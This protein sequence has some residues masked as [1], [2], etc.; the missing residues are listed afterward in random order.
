MPILK[1]AKKA[2][3]VSQRKT[4]INRRIKSQVKTAVDKVKAEPT[5]EN[6]NEAYTAIDMAAKRNI[7][8]HNKAA[9][10]KSQVSKLLGVDAASAK[11]AKSAPAAKKPTKAKSAKSAKTAKASKPAA[12]KK[13]AKSTSAKK[14][15]TDK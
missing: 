15:T 9:R 1:N 4:I 2:L 6:L 14:T 13:P 5:T 8:H 12:T 11:K 3:R 7:F 10:Y